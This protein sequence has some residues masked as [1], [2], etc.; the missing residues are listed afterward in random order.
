MEHMKTIAEIRLENLRTLV[1]QKGTQD[2][3]ATLSDTNPVYLSQ[4]LNRAVDK[5]SGKI[6]QIGDDMA[7]KLE[8]GCEKETGWMDNIHTHAVAPAATPAFYVAEP[9]PVYTITPTVDKLTQ[10]LLDMWHQ[11]D[12]PGKLDLLDK[13]DFYVAG[14]RPH[15]DGTASAVA[16]KK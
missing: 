11:L 10:R 8:R 3:V 16:G 15:Q 2:L 12:A 13:L 7:R 1:E 9:T 6:R 4:L 5:K 14:R